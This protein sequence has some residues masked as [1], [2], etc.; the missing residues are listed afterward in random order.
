MSVYPA[1]LARV[2]NLL[3]KQLTL[4][5]IT[6][7]NLDLYRAQVELATGR[8]VNKTSDD[9][10]K[11][12]TIAEL[13]DRIERSGQ[14]KRN[15]QH[16]TA[17]LGM[18]DTALKEAG[19]TALDAKDIAL[20]QISTPSDATQRKQQAA[21]VSSMITSIYNSMN[22]QGVAGYI[23]GGA[24]TSVQPFVEKNGGYLW[25][26]QGSGLY[27]ELGLAQSVPITLGNAEAFAA[28][29]AKVTGSVDLDPALTTD[30]RLTDT[31]GARG[32]GITPGA[33]EFSFNTATHVAVDLSGADTIGDVIDSLTSA[34]HQ[35]ESDNGV[36]ILGA[37]GIGVSGGSFSID[38][39]TGGSLQFYDQGT[40]VTAQDLGLANADDTLMFPAG[41]SAALDLSPKLT[42]RTPVSALAGLAQSL[43]SIKISN[44]RG[45]ST[46][47]LSGAQTLGD[48][49]GLI[50]AAGV[51]VRVQ[52][53]A[54][55]T[56]IDVVNLMS[57]G[58]AGALSIEET[59]ATNPTAANLGIRS[60]TTSSLL[61]SFNFGRG[62][63]IVDGY[64]D[65]TTG[66]ADATHDID[67]TITL[68]NTA[69][70]TIDIDLRPQ[71]VVSVQSLVDRINS[72]AATQLAAAGLPTNSLV[73]SLGT[74][75]NGIVLTQDPT[76]TSAV[77]VAPRNNS[78]AAEDLGFLDGHYDT[79]S[80]SFVGED[81]AK[82][83]VSGIFSDLIDLRDGL[84]RDD[85]VGIG[86]AGNSLG[87]S[88]D[89]LAETRGV[90]GGYSQRVDFAQRAEED[91]TT[92]D[93]QVRSSLR[94]VDYTEAA[95]RFSMLQTQLQAGLRATALSSQLTLLDYL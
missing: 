46:V 20:Q 41:V 93:E 54:A 28:A 9:A 67:F 5:N 16:A 23:F 51:G 12:A 68:G 35:Y 94:D 47:D 83:R 39:A 48:V 31:A 11:A 89:L 92:F 15:I 33:I 2:P 45:S 65:P 24:T 71:D 66:H 58:S 72:Q 61:S 52:I 59:D 84:E 32:L 79:A 49:K 4:A 25:Q 37:G 78:E 44:N 91:R 63:Q 95:S 18:L 77:A 19:D 62:V 85:T 7:T 50:E 90:V 60:M 26:G 80:A 74:T 27:T 70:T 57:A 86:L 73:A 76:F 42:W 14:R 1:G 53:N 21:I 56:G 87:S 36:T 13:D 64:I 82:V 69:K 10:V 43:G 8:S 22:R 75:S 30:T 40:G 17:S 6:R 29:S 88:I 55:G 3:M 38:V 34:I 81:R